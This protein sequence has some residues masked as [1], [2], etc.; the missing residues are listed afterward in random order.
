MAK[1]GRW[2]PS[3]IAALV[4][5]AFLLAVGVL[6][7]IYQEQLYS[8][9][10]IKGIREQ[11]QILAVSSVVAIQLGDRSAAGKYVNVLQDRKNVV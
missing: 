11:A 8:A 7:A 1:E 10:Q 9:Q 5:A 3:I 6:M 2:S 4:A